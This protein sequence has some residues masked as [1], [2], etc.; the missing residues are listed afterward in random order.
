MV[1]DLLGSAAATG[2]ATISAASIARRNMA[3]LRISPIPLSW[4]RTVHQTGVRAPVADR[5]IPVN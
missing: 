2:V 3:V 1:T 5:K 4:I